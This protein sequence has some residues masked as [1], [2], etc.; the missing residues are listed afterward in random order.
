MLSNLIQNLRYG[1]R[2]LW[3]NP[4]FTAV[5]VLSLALGIGANTA[6]FSLV[7][8]V[9]L[10][11]LPFRDPD[12]LAMIWED[13]T[14]IGFPRDTPAPANY[15]DWKTQNRVFDDV[16]ALNW[17]NYNLTG[18]GEPEKIMAFGVTANLFPLLGVQPAL[19]RDF[20]ADEDKPDAGKVVILSHG[21]WQRRYG[22]VAGILGKEILLNYEKHTVI[23]VMPAGF[24]F[25]QSYIGLW[26]PAAFSQQEL[27]SRGNHYLNVVARLKPGVTAEQAQADIA[28]ITARIAKS[29]PTEAENLKAAVVPMREELA[30]E[31]RRPLMI[32]LA[33]VG[34]VL[35]IA[36]AN[37]ANLLLA[38]AANRRREIAIRT[39]LGASR[40]RI[41]GQLLTESV[42][43]A[44][45]GGSIGLLFASWSFRFLQKLIPPG[46]A[47]TTELKIDSPVLVFALAVSLV[48][49]IIFGLLPALQASKVDFNETLKQGGRGGLSAGGNRLRGALVIAEVALA[50]V[51]L[52]GAGLLIQT[53]YNLQNQYSLFQPEKIL[54]MRTVLPDGKYDE[55]PKRVAF[56]DQVLERL[57]GLPG[58]VSAGY[59]TSMPLQ[60]KGGANGFT[61][62]GRPERNNLGT[63]ANHRQVSAE[64]LQ[65]MGISLREGRYFGNQDDEQAIPVVLVNET[66]AR[67]HWPNESAVGKRIKN[68]RAD[69]TQ[70]WR[71]IVGVVADVRQMG[72]DAPVKAEMYFPY[73]QITSHGFFRPRDLA[74]RTN[75]NP[76]DL[77][78]AAR[79][80]IRAVEPDQPIAN[81]ATMAEQ[82]GEEMQQRRVGMILLASFAA[83]ALLLASLGIY[84]VLAYFVAQHTPE[85]GVRLAL[86][87]QR[88]DVL[89]LVLKKG[90]TLAGAGVGIGLIAGL[91]L[92][93]LMQS[94][95][96]GVN[97]SDPL[98]F[99]SIAALLGGVA[100][101]ACY[102]PARRATNVDPMTAL[103]YE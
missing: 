78:A 96:Y 31:S 27:A 56:Y 58:V 100:F 34:F 23:G 11:P 45:I 102:L 67:Q 68:G 74:I 52:A 89:A 42:L 90:M 103:R 97:A 33:A 26:V 17:L 55:H 24:Q 10:K 35:L 22:G 16:A 3:K 73:R 69:S 21:L 8:E 29:Y 32:L 5:A 14:A 41:V 91:A 59:T 64:Y 92:T 40:S 46:M 62:E 87:A 83:L 7:N 77:V 28:S 101:L 47:Q 61:I 12:R 38:R 51:L 20:S 66:L 30:G 93:R 65:T 36:C 81:I 98:T 86:G 72:L 75:G 6:I 4:G 79:R 49:G 25:L 18:D 84:G 71:T 9:L 80:E 2:G 54:T 95:L 50:L 60:W 63:N 39:A 48:T 70:P 94:L 57:K 1:L 88:R 19:G 13:S 37:I 44:G 76:M 15:V 43:L 99:F 85:I 82:L 53:L